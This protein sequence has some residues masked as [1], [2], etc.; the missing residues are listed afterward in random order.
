[1][2]Q[3]ESDLAKQGLAGATVPQGRD[4]RGPETNGIVVQHVEGDPGDHL[5]SSPVPGARLFPDASLCH[6]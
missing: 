4:D 2:Q 1:M 5:T 6:A 3:G